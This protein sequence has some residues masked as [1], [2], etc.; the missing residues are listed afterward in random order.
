M[1]IHD[2]AEAASNAVYDQQLSS[3]DQR[4]AELEAALAE[5]EAGN[6]GGGTTPPPSTGDLYAPKVYANVDELIEDQDLPTDAN[7]VN[8]TASMGEDLE[9]IFKGLGVNDVL[10]LPNRTQPFRFDSSRGFIAANVVNAEYLSDEDYASKGYGSKIVTG[11]API[12]SSN[13]R[14]WFAMTRARRGIVA[15][16]PVRVEPTDSGWKWRGPDGKLARQPKTDQIVNYK[17]GTTGKMVGVQNKLIE[18]EHESPIFANFILGTRDFGSIAYNGLTGGKEKSGRMGTITVSRVTLDK[19]WHGFAGI[20]NGEAGGLSTQGRYDFRNVKFITDPAYSSSPIMWNRSPGGVARHMDIGKHTI[21]MI[22]FW[23][24]SG[25]NDFFDV[26]TNAGEV[27]INLEEEE[28][29]FELYWE[30]GAMRTDARNDTK[31]W[32]INPSGGS[33][34]VHFKGVEVTLNSGLSPNKLAA[35][36]YGHNGVQKK[37]DTSFDTGETGFVPSA[38]WV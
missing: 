22:T 7:Y 37:S 12:D 11:L 15:L 14:L 16:G 32:N 24:C 33:I 2:D 1:T 29:S 20:P 30:G 9:T 5:C 25:R 4:I 27:G 38:G 31:H 23:R 36:V 26:T 21:G 19:C 3:K 34:G 18:A 35:H 6:G 17:D 8:W 10:V 13:T 28:D